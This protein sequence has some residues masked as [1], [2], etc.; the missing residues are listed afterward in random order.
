M[1]RTT[2]K[3][4]SMKKRSLVTKE[5]A[6]RQHQYPRIPKHTQNPPKNNFPHQTKPKGRMY[7]SVRRTIAYVRDF[8]PKTYMYT[9]ILAKNLHVYTTFG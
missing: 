2:F 7:V 8:W 3:E 4:K 5:V 9:W 6:N 1:T